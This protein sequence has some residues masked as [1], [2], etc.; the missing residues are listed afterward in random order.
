V[1]KFEL[2]SIYYKGDLSIVNCFDFRNPIFIHGDYLVRTK[3]LSGEFSFEGFKLGVKQQIPIT[4]LEL[5]LHNKIV[6]PL[7]PLVLD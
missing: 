6:I 5:F 3:P 4:R 2:V 7:I 1:I